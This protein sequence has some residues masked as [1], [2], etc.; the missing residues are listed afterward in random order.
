MDI[1]GK[2]ETARLSVAAG[3]LML[4]GI[5]LNEW[6]AIATLIYLFIQI[7]VLLPKAVE[8]V[9]VLIRKLRGFRK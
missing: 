2:V 7:V 4:Y 1:D 6:V 5:T 3:G 8:S 9:R